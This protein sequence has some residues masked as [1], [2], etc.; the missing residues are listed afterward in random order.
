MSIVRDAAL[1]RLGLLL[2]PDAMTPLLERSLGRSARV[3]QVRIARVSYKP[4]ERA[5]VHY[6]TLVDGRVENVVASTVAGRDLAA[7]A[8]H[9]GLLELAR[10]ID[11][12]S[13][14]VTPVVHEPD[15]D[16]I[17]AWLPLDPRLPAL[18]E[19]PERLAERLERAGIGMLAATAEPTTIPESYKPGVRI[20]LRFGD[21]ILKAYGKHG[22]YERGVSGLRLA[23][24]SPLR[25]P[26][27]EACL[28]GLRLTAQTAV[29]GDVPSPASAASAAGSL[30]RRLQAAPLTPPRLAGT[31][32]LL[33]LAL[34]KSTLTAKIRPELR[35]RL[36]RLL[37]GLRKTAPS[38]GA[39]VPAHG[40]FDADQLVDA[41]GELVVLD[42]DDVCLA[43]PA[44]DLATYLADVARGRKEDSDAIEAVRAPLLAG[45]GARPAALQWY[46]AAI[47][48][49]RTPHAFQRGLSD[50]PERVEGMV[51]T[52]E[53]VLAG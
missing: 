29:A 6:E 39:L 35:A 37:D 24:A 34:E 33:T 48:L 19:P 1:P 17:L 40:D 41:D 38:G 49:T 20:V 10:R 53:E 50:W 18:A 3:E 21:L 51:R 27:L 16:A 44:F 4:R 15:A 5:S 26:R 45:Y 23:A 25:A 47:V 28:P 32:S 22:L 9:P 14:A 13:P 43:P 46:L 12:R 31:E 36:A 30:A 42:F 52:A 8:R 11:G 2:D 7:M